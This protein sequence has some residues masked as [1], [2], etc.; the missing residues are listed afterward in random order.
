MLPVRS[1]SQPRNSPPQKSG[2][3]LRQI[4]MQK[5]KQQ[6]RRKDGRRAAA[7][8]HQPLQCTAE[9]KFLAYGRQQAQRQIGQRQLRSAG[10]QSGSLAGAAGQAGD[11]A[12][13]DIAQVGQP[14]KGNDA[15]QRRPLGRACDAQVCNAQPGNAQKPGRR[16]HQREDADPQHDGVDRCLGISHRICQ[17][18]PLHP[19]AHQIR[20]QRLQQ[21]LAQ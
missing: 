17:A 12:A 5:R 1:A 2:D 4:Q 16:H 6:C 15:K 9:E 8:P 10:R 13:H 20:S 11:Q 19:Q 21:V 3:P 14:Q 18:G 7:R